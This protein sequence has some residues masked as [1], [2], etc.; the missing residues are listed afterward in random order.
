MNETSFKVKIDCGYY[1]CL[2]A[3]PGKVGKSPQGGDRFIPSRCASNFE[4]GHFK[5][6]YLISSYNLQ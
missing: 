5:V 3:T 6:I 4:L 2:A 1:F